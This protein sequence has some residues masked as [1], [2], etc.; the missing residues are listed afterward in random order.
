MDIRSTAV[1]LCLWSFRTYICALHVPHGLLWRPDVVLA[2]LNRLVHMQSLDVEM[3]LLN[4][5]LGAYP[6]YVTGVSTCPFFTFKRY[7][8]VK[9]QHYSFAG[10]ASNTGGNTGGSTAPVLGSYPMPTDPQCMTPQAPGMGQD[11]EL[12]CPRMVSRLVQR[13]GSQAYVTLYW[14]GA[15]SSAVRTVHVARSSQRGTG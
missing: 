2:L 6:N 15:Y 7:Q 11:L 4:E 9:D 1:L 14:N 3:V 10:N 13:T 8:F 12:P 5:F